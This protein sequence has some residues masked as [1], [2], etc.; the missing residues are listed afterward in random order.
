MSDD[1]TKKLPKETEL[2]NEILSRV[3]LEGIYLFESEI[4]RLSKAP[5]IK[6]EKIDIK[7]D[8][9]FNYFKT[10]ELISFFNLTFFIQQTVE[11]NKEE[12]ED[13]MS[14]S[15]TFTAK[16]KIAGEEMFEKDQIMTFLESAGMLHVWPYWREWVQ[17]M[18]ARAGFPGITI[19]LFKQP[20][21]T[22]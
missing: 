15:A 10:N 1:S 21:V 18:T 16:Y 7:I 8:I 2:S 19:P 22:Q 9:K 17:S 20:I 13:V 6:I 14:F 4:K 11:G 5:Q 12:I 3:A